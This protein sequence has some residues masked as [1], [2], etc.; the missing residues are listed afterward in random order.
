MAIE[1]G[2]GNGRDCYR[3][4]WSEVGEKYYDTEWPDFVQAREVSEDALDR[5]P[6]G[7]GYYLKHLGKVYHLTEDWDSAVS[8]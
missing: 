4:E 7:T 6:D 3:E 8:V 5:D 1:D 2:S